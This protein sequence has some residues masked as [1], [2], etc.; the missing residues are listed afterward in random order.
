MSNP[1]QLTAGQRFGKLT[2]LAFAGVRNRN[3]YWVCRCDCGNETA[4]R[5]HRLLHGKTRSCACL[6]REARMPNGERRLNLVGW[7]SGRL[8]VIAFAEQRGAERKTYWRCRC[9]CGAEVVVWGGN[10]TRSHTHSCGCL[11]RDL[12]SRRAAMLNPRAQLEGR[13]FGRLTVLAFAEMRG[14]K[15][16]WRCA[17]DCGAESIVSVG[18]LTSGK[19]RSCGCLRR[20][21]NARARKHGHSRRSGQSA[22]YISWCSMLTR[23]SNVKVQ[24]YGVYGGAGVKVDPRWDPARGGSFEN[25][26]ADNGERPKGTTFGRPLDLGNYE[27][28]RCRWMTRAE[29]TAE[30]KKKRRVLARGLW[31]LRKA[32]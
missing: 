29:Q 5:E 31:A 7:R 12:A 26:Y 2:V 13:R 20:E 21:A 27:P 30:Q 4:V 14:H 18:N 25:F 9:D 1:A 15:T 32:T 24:N 6:R 16:Y 3:R 17:C 11:Q 22:T 8:V 10:L 19:V 23:C 28:P